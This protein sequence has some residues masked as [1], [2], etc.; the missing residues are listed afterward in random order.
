MK[1]N[2]IISETTPFDAAYIKEYCEDFGIK[3]YTIN[4]DGSIDVDGNVILSY[5]RFSKIP[6]KFRKVSGS[7]SLYMCKSLES[8]EGCPTEVGKSFDCGT[9]QSLTSF[10]YCPKRVAGNFT[11]YSCGKLKSLDGIA[12]IIGGKIDISNCPLITSIAPI[13]T[14]GGELNLTMSYNVIDYLHVFRIKGLKKIRL[15]ELAQNQ[16]EFSDERKIQEI[17]NKHLAGD[18]DIMDCQEELIEAGFEKW[19]RI[20]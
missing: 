12:S 9:C 4:D 7:F 10:D 17:I 14:C 19:A 5:D 1:L 8:L 3:Q 6:I 16:P 20:K 11:A 13:K 2:E 18:R 15:D